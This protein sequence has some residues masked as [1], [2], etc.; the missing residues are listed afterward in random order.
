MKTHSEL[1]ASQRTWRV[2][3]ASEFLSD[4]MRCKLA[5]CDLKRKNL[6]GS[7]TTTQTICGDFFCLTL[8]LYSTGLQRHHQIAARERQFAL[9]QKS[10]AKLDEIKRTYTMRRMQNDLV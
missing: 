4:G 1:C 7:P 10:T 3:F 5:A 8:L 9:Q 6:E 2:R